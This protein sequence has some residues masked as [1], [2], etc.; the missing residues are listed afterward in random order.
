MKILI[1]GA[2]GFIG[3]HVAERLNASGH[4]L[5][6]IVRRSSDRKWIAGLPVE[7]MEGDYFD[8]R[9]VA[10][11][12]A[13]VDMIYHLAGVTKARSRDDYF[14]GNHAV[15]SNLLASVLRVNPGVRRFVHVSS[16]AAVGPSVPGRPVDETAP[17][18]PITTYGV[19]KMEAEKECLRFMEKLPVTIVRPPAVYGPRDT[20]VLEFFR[21]MAMGLQP[22]IGFRTKQVSLIHVADLARGIIMAGEHE[23]SAG[24]TYFISSGKFYDWLEVGNLTAEIMRRKTWRVKVPEWAVYAVAAVAQLLSG[25]GDKPAV[26]NIEKARDIVQDAWIC[27][28]SKAARE[29][30]FREEMTLEEGI[31]STIAWYREAGWLAP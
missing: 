9:F 22:L 23:R 24:Q 17:F 27:D 8:S 6:A 13:G 21:T 11:A 30:G 14:R 12:V 29:L 4:R 10:G 18:R 31:R 15:T 16:Q 1:T 25:L 3:S 7:Y 5:R 26:L 20:D 2:T 19:S 28:A